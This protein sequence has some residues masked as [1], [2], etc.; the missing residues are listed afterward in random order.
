MN[1]LHIAALLFSVSSVAAQE[2]DKPTAPASE[3]NP[4]TP[5]A[6]HSLHGESFNEGPRQAA[7]ILP[8]QGEVNFPV[9]T[10]SSDAQRFVNQGVAQLHTFYYLEAERSF[11]QAAKLDPNCVMAYWGMALANTNNA[12]R[13]KG[14]LK[15]AFEKAAL[16]KIT[17]REQLYL[18]ALNAKHKEGG[19]AKSHRQGMLGHLETIVQD[20]P[21][22]LDARCWLAMAAWENSNSGDG[23]GSRQAVEEL[24]RSVERAAPMHP[25]MHHYRIH[26]W[27]NSKSAMAEKSAGLYA[28][29]APGIAHAWHMP[30]HTYTNLK[31]YADAAYQQ[32]GSARV[33]HAAMFRDRTM[34]FEIHNYAHNNQWLATSLSHAGRPRHG[35]AVARN[36]VEQPRDPARNHKNDGGS[37]QRSGRSRWSELLVRYELWDDLI[38]A[39]ASGALD[40]SD[41]AEEQREMHYSLGLAHAAKGDVAKARAEI[42]ELKKL[43]PAKEEKQEGEGAGKDNDAKAA[44]QAKAD[45][46]PQEKKPRSID[47]KNQ[48]AEIEALVLLLESQN[49]EA[50]KRL[51]DA[52]AMRPELKARAQM[53]AGKLDLALETIRK[54]VDGHSSEV[55]PLACQ[56]ELLQAA[57]KTAEAQDAYARLLG[58][59]KLDEPNVPVF[60]RLQAIARQWASG[61]W[62]RPAGAGQAAGKVDLEGLG[63][64]CWTPN[65]ADHFALADTDEKVWNLSEQR[66]RNVIVLFYLGGKCAHC[67]QQLEAFGKEF[68]AFK[69]AGTDIVAISTDDLAANRTLK[70][71]ED[72][73]K[74][75]M[76]LLVDPEL[77]TFKQYRCFDDFESQPLHG[78]FLIDAQ[79]NVRFHNISYNP[80]MDVEFLK[81][82][83]ARVGRMVGAAANGSVA[84]AAGCK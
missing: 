58:F 21:D 24:L 9:T 46:P 77:R 82:E 13:A 23:I 47:T 15:E 37:A 50:L 76:P 14:F 3:A 31:R 72:N 8:G 40:W 10:T 68:D 30:G 66:G 17:P 35:I 78:T 33:D 83:S 36:L 11:R 84:N 2:P 63:S 75:P 42:E 48:V 64:L 52:K 27:D 28:A 29:A 18:D 16:N 7:V 69:A 54:A 51:E 55:P 74:F 12:K 22:D 56:V 73:I 26:L 6:G 49:D 43:A 44:E 70:A 67:M 41:V 39:T 19:D 71:N 79:G 4:A 80:F 5:A 38:A 60:D 45:K 32:E 57:G 34:P 59:S 62:Q 1:S 20:Y 81:A 61:G 25:G 53:R 65:A